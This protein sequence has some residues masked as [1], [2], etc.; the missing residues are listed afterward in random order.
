MSDNFKVR[1]IFEADTKEANAKVQQM[2]KSFQGL[3]KGVAGASNKMNSNL[4]STRFA[5]TNMNWVIRDSPYI[6]NN[7]SMGVMA[8]SNNIG[9]MIDGFQMVTKETGSM[10]A[11]IKT[12]FA[13]MMGPMGLSIA[14]SIVIAAI[15]AYSFLSAKAGREAK[16]M[17]KKSRGAGEDINFLT[18]SL[19]DLNSKL[20]E[21]SSD[22]MKKGMK[23]IAGE[24]QN[25]RKKEEGLAEARKI[26]LGKGMGFTSGLPSASAKKEIEDLAEK[27]QT[28]AGEIQLVSKLGDLK[29]KIKDLEKDR[30]AILDSDVEAE[31][32]IRKI[33]DAI[34]KLKGTEK[35]LLKSS[36]DLEKER[37]AILKKLREEDERRMEYYFGEAKR[38]KS[39]IEKPGVPG[40][41]AFIPSLE[42]IQQQLD[43]VTDFVQSA[44]S[45]AY[46]NIG[47]TAGQMSNILG[48]AIV[49][50][51]QQGISAMKA[52]EQAFGR[53]LLNMVAQLMSKAIIFGFLNII[54][55]GSI[56]FM[57]NVFGGI[58]GAGGGGGSKLMG[59][60]NS[61][62]NLIASSAG[63]GASPD[64]RR[65]EFLMAKIARKEST[66]VIQGVLEGQTFVRDTV[67]PEL[68]MIDRKAFKK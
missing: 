22:E 14:F 17:G 60:G 19:E 11:G 20:K 61:P 13:S 51:W 39:E 4:K 46:S 54:S 24:I 67:K 10:K 68:D 42:L 33:T 1:A 38:L 35:N 30:K 66:I 8:L 25:I 12:L 2:Q 53:M 5:V 49:N 45:D 34:V 65:M 64:T 23:V 52:F 32:K 36:A 44:W 28:I 63:S 59:G 57:G 37:L 26:F 9:P 62:S 56:G 58:A 27:N 50:Q 3:Q 18:V 6:F 43:P 55:G 47:N 48:G 29:A 40:E 15:Q 31:L 7:F 41:L 21:M 16:E